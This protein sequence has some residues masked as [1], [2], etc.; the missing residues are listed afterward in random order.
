M[1]RQDT[2]NS[3]HKKFQGRPGKSGIKEW[4]LPWNP[5]MLGKIEGRRRGACS[6]MS[7]L[8]GIADVTDM[9]L[10]ELREMVID[11]EAWHVTVHAVTESDMSG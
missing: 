4:L 1:G 6:R 9:K 2:I 3:R 5:L 10:G 11:C 7:W 8:D